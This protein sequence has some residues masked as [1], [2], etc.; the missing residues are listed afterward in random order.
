MKRIQG[1]QNKDEP[2]AEEARNHTCE[3]QLKNIA[4]S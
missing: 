2:A 3:I 1:S 4:N